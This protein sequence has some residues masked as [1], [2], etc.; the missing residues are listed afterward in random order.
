MTLL[1]V[2]L[3]TFFLAF[4]ASL[5]GSKSG[6]DRHDEEEVL[7]ALAA[8]L[9]AGTGPFLEDPTHLEVLRQGAPISFA[10]EANREWRVLSEVEYR[11]G[12][13]FGSFIVQ[14]EVDRDWKSDFSGVSLVTLRIERPAIAAADERTSYAVKVLTSS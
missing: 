2:T 4:G 8:D 1:G 9:A 5:T 10:F 11:K 13:D 12:V 14:I 7:R 3:P 6:G